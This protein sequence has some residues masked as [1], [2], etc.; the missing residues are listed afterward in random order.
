M[1]LAD[2]AFGLPPAAPLAPVPLRGP[3]EPLRHGWTFVRAELLR[4]VMRDFGASVN[5][6]YLSCLSGA[7]G[8]WMRERAGGVP[9]NVMALMPISIRAPGR[10]LE[11]GNRFVGA[12]VRLPVGE[13]D[14]ARRLTAVMERTRA[15]RRSSARA[16]VE[17]LLDR[18]PD[19]VAT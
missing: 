16:E 12:R 6:I 9:R 15:A 1:A 4:P 18:C 10:E 8:S 11:D 17:R 2:F 5:D 14:P 3:D 19:A 7:L 13:T